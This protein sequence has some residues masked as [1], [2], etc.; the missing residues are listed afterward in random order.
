MGFVEKDVVTRSSDGRNE[1][2]VEPLHYETEDSPKMLIT[3]P[4]GADTDG[5]S[6]PRIFW[7]VIPPTG[8]Y[9]MAAV[10]HD[11]MYRTNMFVKSKCDSL[12]LE[13]MK[14]LGVGRVKRETIYL[15][16][17]YFGFMAYNQARRK[18]NEGK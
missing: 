17:K 6:V 4:A 3:V 12:F 2:L 11:Y 5:A 15:A 10:L 9:W 1:V 16:V 18:L 14:S 13:A 7:R 8:N